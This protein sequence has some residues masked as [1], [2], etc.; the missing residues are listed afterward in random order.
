MDRTQQAA[1][2]DPWSSY[3]SPS[4]PPSLHSSLAPSLSDSY[5]VPFFLQSLICA[6]SPPPKHHPLSPLPCFIPPLF[7]TLF[8]LSPSLSPCLFPPTHLSFS[9]SFSSRS[10]L[11]TP[12]SLLSLSFPLSP[13]HRFHSVK[14]WQVSE[15]YI[16]FSSEPAS[17]C[18][19]DAS[20]ITPYSLHSALLDQGP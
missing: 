5:H 11:S 17:P 7:P 15:C 20:Q 3:T 14:A 6:E 18:I 12:P 10:S 9:L 16:L 19:M 13:A 1:G 2:W 4:L 8:P